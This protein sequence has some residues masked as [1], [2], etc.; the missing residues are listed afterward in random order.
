MLPTED[1]R[2]LLVVVEDNQLSL[3][4]G[5]KG[6]NARL[7]VKLTG[8]RIDIKTAGEI[9][10]QGIDWKTMMLQFA[11]EEQKRLAEQRIAKQLEEAG[12][13]ESIDS[14][15]PNRSCG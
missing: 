9:E 3:A 10:E 4:I 11:A 1:K 2:S 12:V 15:M 5:K 14:R 6:K 13:Q 7:A 8:M